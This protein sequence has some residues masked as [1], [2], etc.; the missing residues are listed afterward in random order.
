[1]AEIRPRWEWRTFGDY[2]GATAEAAFVAMTGGC[3]YSGSE[4][5]SPCGHVLNSRA[6]LSGEGP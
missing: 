1:M 2:F 6:R 3:R 5:S 4:L